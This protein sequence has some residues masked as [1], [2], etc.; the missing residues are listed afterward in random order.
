MTV[1]GRGTLRPPLSG[2]DSA[3]DMFARIEDLDGMSKKAILVVALLAV[4]LLYVTR[5]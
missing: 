2:E 5:R 4:A 3:T 1:G